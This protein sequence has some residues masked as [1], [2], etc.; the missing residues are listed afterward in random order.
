M[1]PSALVPWRI[2]AN[3]YALRELHRLRFAEDEDE[4]EVSVGYMSA[5][6]PLA[7]LKYL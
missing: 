1:T 7:F 4:L 5:A 2:Y 3:P 6:V